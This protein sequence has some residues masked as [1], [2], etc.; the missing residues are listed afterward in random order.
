LPSAAPIEA[1]SQGW[2]PAHRL[3]PLVR[4]RA[5]T[6][7]PP[8]ARSRPAEAGPDAEAIEGVMIKQPGRAHLPGRPKGRGGSGRDPVVD[9]V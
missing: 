9:A 4:L 7:L 3:S 2:T 1:V 8:P 6:R 5:G